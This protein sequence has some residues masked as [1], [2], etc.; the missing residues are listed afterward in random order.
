MIERASMD[1]TGRTLIHTLN[2][3]LMDIALDHETQTL[4][5]GNNIYRHI[6][7]SDAD[8]S[9]RRVLAS[10]TLPGP[11]WSM[12][13]FGGNI[14]TAYYRSV[15]SIS[16]IMPNATRIRY[17]NII[18]CNNLNVIK[19]VSPARQLPGDIVIAVIYIYIII[20]KSC[21]FNYYIH[22]AMLMHSIESLW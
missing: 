8:G 9:N 5:W 21:K 12:D 3:T 6:E 2:F 4:Y 19:V 13:Y 16:S 22:N 15:M 11:V 14:F 10:S 7:S 18:Q 17:N 20:L 1:G